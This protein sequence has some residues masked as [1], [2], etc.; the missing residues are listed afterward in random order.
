MMDME[1]PT[2]TRDMTHMITTT[3]IRHRS[4]C[5][6]VCVCVC[7][8]FVEAEPSESSVRVKGISQSACEVIS[9]RES[10]FTM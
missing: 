8:C 9:E 5:V 1:Q 4:K 7:V 10:L 6:C 3:T 2:M